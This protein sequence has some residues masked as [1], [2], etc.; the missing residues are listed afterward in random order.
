MSLS[1]N[2]RILILGASFDTGNMG[3]N[4]LAAGAIQC[5]ISRF[6]HASVSLLDY[7]RES[8]IYK[9]QLHDTEVSIPLINIRFSKKFYLSNNIALL[10]LLAILLKLI[11]STK[12]RSRI[13]GRNNCL[14]EIC[15][16]D[17]VA[18]VSGGD[19]F[20]DIYGLQR[21]LYVS[22]PQVLVI[23]LGKK[24]ILLPQTIGPFQHALPKAIARY[25]LRR[26]ERIYARDYQSLKEVEL[27]LNDTS[28]LQKASFCYDV[29][30]SVDPIPPA[31][32]EIVGLST[33]G[34]SRVG[35]NISG[36][37]WMGGYTRTNMF[38][39]KL[40][41]K[42][43]VYQLIDL[44]VGRLDTDVLLVPHVFGSSAESDSIVCEQVFAELGERYKGRL[45]YV[46]GQLNQ[47]E[48]KHV[49]GSCDFFVGS[50]MHAC[51]AA[52]S[53]SVPAVSLAYSDK[54]GAVM[55][56]LGVAGLVVDPRTMNPVDI[57]Q[58]A[59]RAY[60][61]RSCTR[62]VLEKK[63]PEVRQTLLNLFEFLDSFQ[64]L[65]PC[66]SAEALPVR[67]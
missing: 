17:A 48:I 50:R 55:Q 57:L 38:G 60:A 20:S 22:L 42:E 21:L 29:A 63:L 14:R 51:I 47:S 65:T 25:L 67:A 39:L 33:H 46:R 62:Q 5:V 59:E 9:L 56:T 27:L 30:F 24:L 26:A 35:V 34:R 36:L 15:A 2:A 64:Q 1:K 3:V 7:G 8:K 61:E 41:Y 58:A 19:S 10:L 11:P 44:F 49:I 4:A 12:L 40:N 45:G 13:I 31:H 37:L 43:L 54:F 28:A 23:L 66:G 18:A 6:P 32:L 52:L 53:Q 16:A